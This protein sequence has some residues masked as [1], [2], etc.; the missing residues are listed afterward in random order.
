MLDV[1]A[2]R[3]FLRQKR[4][5]A[6]V[7]IVDDES[8]ICDAVAMA[9]EEHDLPSVSVETAEAACDLLQTESFDLLVSDKN[10]PM[11]SGLDLFARSVEL[12]PDM[13]MV[14]MTGY[15]SLD[16]V[17]EAISIGAIDY[18]AKPFDDIFVVAAKLAKIVE[19]RQNLAT[20]EQIAGALLA[21]IRETGSD[22]QLSRL[23]GH[24][25]GK[26]KQ[27][28]AT[29]P[30]VI[31][32]EGEEVCAEIAAAF[33]SVGLRALSASTAQDVLQL[34]A[35]NPT[36]SVGVLALDN[37]MSTALLEALHAERHV[38]VVMSCTAPDLRK[39]LAAIAMGATDL[40][41]RDVEDPDTLA[42][43][44]Q[45]TI[46]VVQREQLFTMLFAT[47]HLHSDFIGNELV[48]LINELVPDAARSGLTRTEESEGSSDASSV[49]QEL[50]PQG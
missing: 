45:H 15:A 27:T 42:A 10:L 1:S 35:E 20:Y 47:L 21:Q 25:L 22:S 48:D 8:A 26:F 7:L 43:R 5:G 49:L 16:S 37:P 31:I 40:Y 34:L 14:M 38:N 12:A 24:K 3:E 9:L 41:L 4:E 29:S 46:Q 13:P 44:L 50:S 33:E 39:T 2:I 28:L 6:R 11:M 17:Q 18:I 30:D 32:F 36:V 23:I 19:R